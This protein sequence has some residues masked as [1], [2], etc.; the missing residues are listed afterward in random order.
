MSSSDFTDE[1]DETADIDIPY[2]EWIKS[3]DSTDPNEYL[4]DSNNEKEFIQNFTKPPKNFIDSVIHAENN[5]S[6]QN[7]KEFIGNYFNRKIKQ[8]QKGFSF[9]STPTSPLAFIKK[10]YDNGYIKTC[11][12]GRFRRHDVSDF[13]LIK[14]D[15][16]ELCQLCETGLSTSIATHQLHKPIH[17]A[18]VIHSQANKKISLSQY[19]E[20]KTSQNNSESIIFNQDNLSTYIDGI[21][22]LSTDGDM[23]ILVLE[24]IHSTDPS[25]NSWK[26]CSIYNFD[27]PKTDRFKSEKRLSV[28]TAQIDLAIATSTDKNNIE[29]IFL[30]ENW[31]QLCLQNRTPICQINKFDTGGSV[32]DIAF[33]NVYDGN[34]VKLTQHYIYILVSVINE[35]GSNTFPNSSVKPG[36]SSLQLYE[37]FTKNSADQ[38]SN[39]TENVD[40]WNF[41]SSSS[42]IGHLIISEKSSKKF[43]YNV[44]PAG[45]LPLPSNIVPKKIVPLSLIKKSA[46]VFTNTEALFVKSIQIICGD[47]NLYKKNLSGKL[48]H[49]DFEVKNG[50]NGTVN[51]VTASNKFTINDIN[52]KQTTDLQNLEIAESNQANLLS[53]QNSA[54]QE[55]SDMPKI[56]NSLKPP[57]K[58][59]SNLIMAQKNRRVPEVKKRWWDVSS[60]QP[61]IKKPINF[62]SKISDTTNRDEEYSI[63]ER[64]NATSNTSTEESTFNHYYSI[65]FGFVTA[66]A[67]SITRLK[68]EIIEYLVP[69]QLEDHFYIV[70]NLGFIVLVEVSATPSITFT[71]LKHQINSN[72][73]KSTTKTTTLSNSSSL[74]DMEDYFG[75]NSQSNDYYPNFIMVL[76]NKIISQCNKSIA[77]DH[78]TRNNTNVD[79]IFTIDNKNKKVFLLKKD[80]FAE[81]L[82]AGGNSF[83]NSFFV[84]ISKRNEFQNTCCNQK[85]KLSK[86]VLNFSSNSVN[87]ESFYLFQDNQFD[88]NIS[89]PL[90]CSWRC[91]LQSTI[92]TRNPTEDSNGEYNTDDKNTNIKSSAFILDHSN[93]FTCNKVTIDDTIYSMPLTNLQ[94]VSGKNSFYTVNGRNPFMVSSS[95]CSLLSTKITPSSI[96]AGLADFYC[97]APYYYMNRYD[98]TLRASYVDYLEKNDKEKFELFN[99]HSEHSLVKKNF[100]IKQQH[101]IPVQI[102]IKYSVELSKNESSLTKKNKSISN[103]EPIEIRNFTSFFLLDLPFYNEISLDRYKVLV[104]SAFNRSFLSIYKKKNCETQEF[105]TKNYHK[106]NAKNNSSNY[107]DLKEL[108]E[109]SET[110]YILQLPTL[111]DSNRILKPTNSLLR[112]KKGFK[113]LNLDCNNGNLLLIVQTTKYLLVELIPTQTDKNNF[114]DIVCEIIYSWN[115]SDDLQQLDKDVNNPIEEHSELLDWKCISHASANFIDF[116]NKKVLGKQECI[117]VTCD[118][119]KKNRGLV[120]TVSLVG[121]YTRSKNLQKN[122]S[123]EKCSNISF[124]NTLEKCTVNRVLT[125]FLCSPQFNISFD[126]IKFTKIDSNKISNYLMHDKLYS[127]SISAISSFQLEIINQ[128]IKTGLL[129]GFN[130]SDF[131]FSVINFD[132]KLTKSNSKNYQ[133]NTN[134]SNDKKSNCKKVK[135]GNKDTPKDF[136][137]TAKVY[138]IACINIED[139]TNSCLRHNFMNNFKNSTKTVS[140]HK[141]FEK[142]SINSPHS[143]I[144]LNFMNYDAI[145]IG[146]KSGGVVMFYLYKISLKDLKNSS[147]KSEYYIWPSNYQVLDFGFPSIKL[148]HDKSLSNLE[149]DSQSFF[150]VSRNSYKATLNGYGI[151]VLH[152]LVFPEFEFEDIHTSEE[153]K[154]HS[155]IHL[156]PGLNNRKPST[157]NSIV[158]ILGKIQQTDKDKSSKFECYD[159]LSNDDQILRILV[160]KK[161][162]MITAQLY[163]KTFMPYKFINDSVNN[164]LIISGYVNGS[165]RLKSTIKIVDNLSNVVLDS[166][167]LLKNEVVSCMNLWEIQP[168]KRKNIHKISENLDFDSNRLNKECKFL[169]VGTSYCES[170][171]K[172]IG[173]LLFYRLKDEIKKSE[174]LSSERSNDSDKFENNSF[175]RL[176]LKFVWQMYTAKPVDAICPIKKT[177]FVAIGYDTTM[178]VYQLDIIKKLWVE[179]CSYQLKWPI[180]SIGCYDL[181]NDLRNKVTYKNISH[182]KSYLDN[183]IPDCWLLNVSLEQVG[184][185][186]FA[187]YPPEFST[188]HFYTSYESQRISSNLIEQ[189]DYSTYSMVSSANI[190]T[191]KDGFGT[192]E[193]QT[194]SIESNL[195]DTQNVILPISTQTNKNH[196]N[197]QIK[198]DLNKSTLSELNENHSQDNNLFDL[199]NN[200]ELITSQKMLNVL[201]DAQLEL[202]FTLRNGYP[203]FESEIISQNIVTGIDK[204][205]NFHVL[206][207]PPLPKNLLSKLTKKLCET[208]NKNWYFKSDT[209]NRD[210]INGIL[211][212]PDINSFKSSD[213]ALSEKLSILS[214]NIYD[215]DINNT[216]NIN[217]NQDFSY[218]NLKK[219]DTDQDLTLSETYLLNNPSLDYSNYGFDSVANFK[220]NIYPTKL[221]KNAHLSVKLPYSRSISHLISNN[222]LNSPNTK[223]KLLLKSETEF[224]SRSALIAT[225]TGAFWSAAGISSEVYDLLLILQL[226][227]EYFEVFRPLFLGSI[228]FNSHDNPKKS[229]FLYKRAEIKKLILSE[230]EK[231]I[232]QH[233]ILNANILTQ[234]FFTNNFTCSYNNLYNI[235]HLHNCE[236]TIKQNSKLHCDYAAFPRTKWICQNL[237]LF[238]PFVKNL[239]NKW[240]SLANTEHDLYAIN[241]L[242]RVFG[243]AFL[244]EKKLHE[245]LNIDY[246]KELKLNESNKSLDDVYISSKNFSIIYCESNLLKILPSHIDSLLIKKVQF[247][248]IERERHGAQQ[249]QAIEAQNIEYYDPHKRTEPRW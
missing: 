42:N 176:R 130:N 50:K 198:S 160:H 10:S 33:L 177:E 241:N 207:I 166:V 208:E 188:K 187:F 125:F 137:Y 213:S 60:A 224:Q 120:L 83:L 230:Y 53:Q 222:N 212:D 145:V 30:N 1:N 201:V 226:A 124:N 56:N 15:S 167:N 142:T 179:C 238:Y 44:S 242:T 146:L 39:N 68:S 121:N 99:K 152:S 194:D 122:S 233:K 144:M 143:F 140:A 90:L 25:I 100:L 221:I 204:S 118:S 98:Q 117:N 246:N 20:S 169:L 181:S 114:M 239:L 63:A 227:L 69:F 249:A 36:S 236:C 84:A 110:V 87:Q 40:D 46:V 211:A 11:L 88:C 189:S 43:R 107:S 45:R 28:T 16:I 183:L 244:A 71:I 206:S 35:F 139:S 148:Y 163:L 67:S 175:R 195:N 156:Q 52:N 3:F 70:T 202:L 155:N 240:I 157:L 164:C 59:R 123:F 182:A 131:I 158:Q 5:T 27:S 75:L 41:S 49:N 113:A 141:Q 168:D 66:W 77:S 136:N 232:K 103:K 218:S 165:N 64:F 172:N 32:N 34:S 101:G 21:I 111:K 102:L 196:F 97:H 127:S 65:D 215:L 76:D 12:T 85:Q 192:Q 89:R 94:V 159:A 13:I 18:A 4:S 184:L 180:I 200:E 186:L 7:Y 199:Y 38:K 54:Q 47:I 223:N 74:V 106:P 205:G 96:F 116:S 134:I 149:S 86:N 203:L 147:F 209:F 162:T 150:I 154:D 126:N 58:Y 24:K 210:Y 17:S 132:Q 51:L 185:Q 92:L 173:R 95:T 104:S 112:H 19:L 79:D 245:S 115:I 8:K 37:C 62:H 217:F 153:Y 73:F 55:S 190:C 109:A 129:I 133:S 78:E 214:K 29:I 235:E 225:R 193:D 128:K 237:E 72:K 220:L 91:D 178:S 105:E 57:N 61:E 231:S 48:Y 161:P 219:K 216:Y 93:K 247:Q 243:P 82:F 80:I 135:K 229:T 197:P 248:Y 14:E 6:R 9:S 228:V 108:L 234:Y 151:L 22:C 170:K 119:N 81:F 31:R 174:N 191:F 138:Q 2:S 26:F 23:V 171:S